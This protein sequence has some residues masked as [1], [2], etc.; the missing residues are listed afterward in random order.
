MPQLHR[1]PA[2]TFSAQ[3]RYLNDLVYRD[4]LFVY[5][6][7]LK[8]NSMNEEVE[9]YPARPPHSVRC[10]FQE[11]ALNSQHVEP[12]RYGSRMANVFTR[13]KGFVKWHDKVI[14]RGISMLVVS[15]LDHFDNVTGDYYHTEISCQ[16]LEEPGSV[17]TVAA[18]AV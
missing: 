8:K 12:A 11:H 4:M 9:E 17:N 10:S 3:K 13:F 18:P 6:V 7:I 16:Y 15:V 14:C 5:S 2:P 1:A